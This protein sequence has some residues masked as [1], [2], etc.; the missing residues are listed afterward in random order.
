MWLC[1]SVHVLVWLSLF[2]S[3]LLYLCER[4]AKRDSH[5]SIP[6]CRH[7]R[8]HASLTS[9]C[10]VAHASLCVLVLTFHLCSSC[11]STTLCLWLPPDPT[12]SYPFILFLFFPFPFISLLA[13]SLPGCFL[14][15]KHRWR[16]PFFMCAIPLCVLFCPLLSLSFFG[17]LSP[18]RSN[19]LSRFDLS[20]LRLSL[21]LSSGKK[22]PQQ[23]TGRRRGG[24]GSLRPQSSFSSFIFILN[25][26]YLCFASA[27]ACL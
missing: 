21:S 10:F 8:L 27:P 12:V 23:H 15:P 14:S 20:A 5:T 11:V 2:V 24:R 3:P 19:L 22:T 17:S 13:P 25:H 26:V 4:E 18:A 7:I 9:V 1:A 16:L 6:L